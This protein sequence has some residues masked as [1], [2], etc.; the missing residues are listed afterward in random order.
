M[1]KLGENTSRIRNFVFTYSFKN[2]LFITL[3]IETCVICHIFFNFCWYF[4]NL[5]LL[6]SK[7]KNFNGRY[8]YFFAQEGFLCLILQ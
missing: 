2:A 4:F 6:P 5:Q 1:S 8:M 3:Y 7:V